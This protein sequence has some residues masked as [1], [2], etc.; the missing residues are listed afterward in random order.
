MTYHSRLE[1]LD[2]S[3]ADPP[4]FRSSEL[5]WKQSDEIVLGCDRR[6]RVFGVRDDDADRPPTVIV[7]PECE[8]DVRPRDLVVSFPRNRSVNGYR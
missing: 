8:R 4:T 5:R 7:N 3:P 1:G 6:L 2:G